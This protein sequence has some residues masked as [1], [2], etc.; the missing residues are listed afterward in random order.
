MEHFFTDPEEKCYVRTVED[1]YRIKDELIQRKL[2][3]Y[4]KKL[5]GG[6]NVVVL[7]RV[8]KS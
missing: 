3:E 5:H 6:N 2:E 8:G 7:K 1:Y 4:S